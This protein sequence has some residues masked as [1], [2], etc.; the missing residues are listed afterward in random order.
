MNILN[1]DLEIEKHIRKILT[2]LSF[3]CCLNSTPVYL[4]LDRVKRQLSKILKIDVFELTEEDRK[5]LNN[6]IIN[7]LLAEI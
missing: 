3:R 2:V 7:N 5:K 6:L 4:T 1:K